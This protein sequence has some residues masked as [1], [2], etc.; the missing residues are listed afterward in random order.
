MKSTI[1]LAFDQ[2]AATTVAAVLLPGQRTAALHTLTSDSAT[3]VR[4]VERMRRQGAVR[5]CYEAGPCGFELQRA[6]AARAIPCDVIAP[7]LIPRRPGDRIKTDRRDASQLAILYRAGALTAIHIPTDHEE[8]ARDVLRCREDIRA[9]LL[10]ARHRLSKFLLRHGRRFTGT[11]KAWSKRHYVWLRA[12]T[13]PIAAL[14]QTH[15]A[16]LRAVEEIEARLRD[17]ETELRALL[18]LEPLRDR[19]QRLRCFRGID[20]L[21]ALTIAAELGDARRFGTAPSTMAFVGLVPSEHSSGTKRAQGGI[22]K[23]GNAHL[24]RVLV[25]SAWHPSLTSFRASCTGYAF[26][27][28]TLVRIA[29]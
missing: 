13:W 18:D 21:T 27:R 4:F 22:T 17:I 16:Y 12:Q 14:D 1:I 11:K 23:T 9:D 6:L 8:A 2:H 3:V 26:A 20:D 5:C 7:A 29:S 25:E 15:R 28:S 10:R 24:R 19:V